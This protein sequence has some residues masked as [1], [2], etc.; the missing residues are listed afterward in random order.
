M[1]KI[2]LPH[3]HGTPTQRCLDKIPTKPIFDET[4]DT[5]GILGDPTR[6]KILWFLCHS[7]ECVAKIA[8]VMGM[9]SPAVSHH[10][11]VLKQAGILT[12]RK[13]G[14]EVYYTLSSTEYAG[15]VHHIVDIA[16]DYKC[17]EREQNEKD[18]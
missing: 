11:K 7:E 6:I 14:K 4:A 16:V 10:L 8:A 18:L 3:D 1:A 12:S 15:L 9:S 13:A 2:V 17:K 5:L